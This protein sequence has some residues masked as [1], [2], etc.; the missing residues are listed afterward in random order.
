MISPF[1]FLL[2]LYFYFLG[3]GKFL[4]VF[5]SLFLNPLFYLLFG[6]GDGWLGG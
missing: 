6:G 5:F 2:L 1:T 3:R 4:E